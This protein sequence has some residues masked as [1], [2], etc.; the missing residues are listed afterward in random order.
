M[1]V[2]VGVLTIDLKANTA[3]FTQ[4]MDKMST[5]SAKTATDIK[6][7][8]E[9]IALAGVAM[10]GAV[11]TGTIALIKGALDSA[12]AFGKMAQSAGTTVETL[13]TLNYAA[14][15]SNV[16]TEQL[17]KGLEMLSV[18]A[19]K[20][21]NGNV[22]LKRI[23]DRL[24]VSVTDS[25]GK[26]KDSGILMEELAVKF[27]KL[28]DRGGKTPFAKALFGKAGAELIPLLN[29]YGEDQAKITEEAHRFGMV[30]STSTTEVSMR[31]H[32]NLDRLHLVLKGIGFSILSATLPALDK[33]LQ[34]LIDL[35]KNSDLQ[36]LAKQ[37][38]EKVTSAV[39]ALGD[40]LEFATKHA[41]ALKLALEAIIALKV[42]SIVI[43]V[44]ADLAQAGTLTKMAEG[45]S[46]YA[47]SLL[48]IGA[49]AK[50]LPKL[51]G[52]LSETASGF[53][54]A[55]KGASFMQIV[56]TGVSLGF[57]NLTKS[58]GALRG[59]SVSGIFASIV[60][61]LRAIPGLLTGVISGIMNVGRAG[62]LAAL[63]NPY[64]AAALA[65]VALIGLLIAFRN[66]TFRIGSDT[67]KIRDI[68]MAVWIGMG[69]IVHWL[70]DEISKVFKGIA[71]AWRWL[72]SFIKDTGPW[73]WLVQEA[74]KA[75]DLIA[76]GLEKIT[77]HWAKNLLDE[78][79]KRREDA[80]AAAAA[81]A[82]G[83]NDKDK[84]DEKDKKDKHDADTSGLGKDTE[85][86]VHK[87]L[88]NLQEK[89]DESKQTLAAAGLQEEAQRKVTAANKANNEILK[90][91]QEIAKQTGAKT[92]DYASL[93]NAA[94]QATIRSRYAQIS[95][96]EAKAALLD[97]IGKNSRAT[98]LS[99]SQSKLMTAAMDKGYEA[100]LR[101]T[102][103]TQALTELGADGDRGATEEQRKA[104]AQEI[105]TGLV[106]NER[107][108]IIDNIRNMNDELAAKRI[109]TDATLGS[110]DALDAAALSARLYAI[111]QQIA[112]AATGELKDALVKQ[113]EQMIANHNEDLRK[114]AFEDA[115]AFRDPSAQYEDQRIRLYQVTQ[116]L[117]STQ[118]GV[119]TYGQTLQV[120]MAQ[121]ENFNHLID[122]TVKSLLYEGSA[123]N[124]MKAFFLDMQKNAVTAA[125]IIYEA[126]HTA[127]E[128]VS[129][130][131]AELI[132]GGK[133]DFGKMFQDIGK[134]MVKLS[135]Q[136]AMQKGLA[137]LG[138]GTK[139]DGTPGNPLNVHI[140]SAAKGLADILGGGEQD[141]HGMR[142]G[143]GA[144]EGDED[145]TT[146]V[147]GILDKLKTSMSGIWSKISGGL[148]SLLGHIGGIF[149]K[150][151][152]GLSGG[153]GGIFTSLLGGLIP[154]AEG[155]SV[156][157]SNAY[158]VGERG[159]EVLT[160]MSGN[161]TSN[162]AAR[163]VFGASTGPTLFY[164]IDA[165]GT[166]PAQ[167]EQ[168]TRTALLAVHNSS[169]TNAVQVQ[170][171]RMK[172]VPQR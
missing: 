80:E 141:M 43:P 52:Y 17:V 122:E 12:D 3:S 87:V 88:S 104:R 105:Y 98:A 144:E 59:L 119:L 83:D 79:K 110:V 131:V 14:Q 63:S 130:N 145:K 95:D 107:K 22:E 60:S 161:I 126:L 163:R 115:R 61:G 38:G 29:Q 94:T 118:N 125:E 154:H 40:A 149:G 101:Q 35:A 68:F 138:V 86:P 117:K 58:L 16:S 120:A 165:R 49:A 70:G 162:A 9:K 157:P 172:R 137:A 169:V 132:T 121:Q 47:R 114:R 46:A 69:K 112:T 142:P 45:G 65:I 113:R 36:G 4:S 143:V 15:L 159:P 164:S 153:F 89:L 96:N 170:A 97:L 171:D 25:N 108:A 158:L 140:I 6:R 135:L 151:A 8:L 129:D 67:Y 1:S 64:T 72:T 5:L 51:G 27:A 66:H 90:L 139:P 109:V 134:Q 116:A 75:G 148:G 77:P 19:F 62:L 106:E 136:A 146:G 37:F 124:G 152:G 13:T 32:D 48:G 92:K 42:G 168:R 103:A 10:A 31:A 53:Y 167:T 128:R 76:K 30:L 2:V 81:A 93:V 82:K 28:N 156:S 18:S 24:G 100:T 155:G 26:L 74:G 23:Y 21:Q 123:S 57:G 85:S 166:D 11:A 39:D 127:F 7:S 84:K 56:T 33:L 111:D 133:A 34:K 99:I 44:I 160:G 73:K 150:I 102:A 71:D 55:A 147:S 50:S 54:G 20:A 41:H 78:A 91:G